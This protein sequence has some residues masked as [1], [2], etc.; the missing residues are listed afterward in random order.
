M[1]SIP[2]F[3]KSNTWTHCLKTTA[4]TFMGTAGRK[5]WAWGHPNMYLPNLS[6]P[7]LGAV[8]QVVCPARPCASWRQL[9]RLPLILPSL[10]D[11]K[12]FPGCSLV[13]NL[14]AR[15]EMQILSQGEE[16]PVEKEMATHSSI[17][18]WRTPRI[19]K[20]GGLKAMRLQE[21]D[22]T[23]QLN[24]NRPKMPKVSLSLGLP[25]CLW[26]PSGRQSILALNILALSSTQLTFPIRLNRFFS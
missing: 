26:N 2:F 20:P 10:I 25:Y 1:M 12:G 4:L 21:S 19:K 8:L 3:P 17:L 15:Q 5:A 14:S 16:D 18:A 11:L 24:N 23:Q 6:H 7:S 9:F 22:T 13:K